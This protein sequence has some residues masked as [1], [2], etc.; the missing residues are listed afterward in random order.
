MEG[1]RDARAH[2][3]MAAAFT[4]L[5][6]LPVVLSGSAPSLAS[7]SLPP[8]SSALSAEVAPGV[9][10]WSSPLFA[11]FHY[12]RGQVLGTYVQF[13]YDPSGGAIESVLGLAGDAPVLYVGS[14]LIEGFPPARTPQAQGSTFQADGYL[15]SITAHDDPTI[16]I[17]IRTDVA[18]TARI[19]LPAEATNVT[20][21]ATIG[22][23]PASSLTYTVGGEQAR[24][25]LGTGSFR[26]DGIRVLAQMGDSDLLVFKALPP[27]AAERT[28]WLAVL[29]AISAGRI[30]AEIDLVATSE[31]QWAQNIVEYRIGVAG[32]ALDVKR[33][34][35]ALQVDS[36]LEGGA[37]VL[38][39]FDAATM[40]SSAS[41]QLQV[42]T[43]SQ[44]ANRSES[45]L[46]TFVSDLRRGASYSVLSLPGTVVALY[47]PSLAAVSV[48]VVSS[49]PR[50]LGAVFQADHEIAMIAALAVVSVAAAR[51][52]RR[53]G[54]A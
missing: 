21:Q 18:R 20:V 44:E 25:L 54:A 7:A 39:G 50:A 36:L 1:G 40:P 22:S 16:L 4:V 5:S 30:V 9:F 46:P 32:W 41:T 38:L 3:A 28:E 52:F 51:M 8:I 19:E 6:L 49:P 45:P 47:L 12:D 37:V 26:V 35:A 13:A 2:L 42:R 27:G 29:D 11:A 31:G 34:R 23:W 17:Q 15:A 24:F 33:G 48:E 53:R 10:P 14:I 43:N